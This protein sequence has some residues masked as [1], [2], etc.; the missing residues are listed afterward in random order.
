VKDGNKNRLRDQDIHKIVD[1]FTKQAEIEKYSRMVPLAETP[2]TSRSNW[3]KDNRMLSV[4]LPIEVVVFSGLSAG[5]DA[6]CASRQR[7][8][9]KL[10]ATAFAEGQRNADC[11]G[12][13]IMVMGGRSP[14]LWRGRSSNA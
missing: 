6:P 1:A 12:T 3:A 7:H 11:Q 4:S 5:P 14:P 2:I 8:D 9:H 10:S 13:S